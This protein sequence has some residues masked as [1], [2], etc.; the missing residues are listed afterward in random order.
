MHTCLIFTTSYGTSRTGATHL[1]L[2]F[3]WGRIDMAPPRGGYHSSSKS[4]LVPTLL[5]LYRIKYFIIALRLNMCK[6]RGCELALFFQTYEVFQHFL[7]LYVG[8]GV[9]N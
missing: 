4:S 8:T 1:P 6:S 3:L 9:V 2:C 7:I 5:C